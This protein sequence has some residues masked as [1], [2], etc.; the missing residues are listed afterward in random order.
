MA[1]IVF[2]ASYYCFSFTLYLA[3]LA[4]PET[5]PYEAHAQSKTITAFE[6]PV[7]P[8]IR[9]VFQPSCPISDRYQI[10]RTKVNA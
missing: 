3:Q 2:Q 6:Q 8:I 7:I 9:F 1:L 10:S 4:D 5:V